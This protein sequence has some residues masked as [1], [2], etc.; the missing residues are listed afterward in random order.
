MEGDFLIEEMKGKKP[1]GEKG[2]I[3]ESSIS[4]GKDLS[5]LIPPNNA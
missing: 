5:L 2:R 3:G 1:L 4:R